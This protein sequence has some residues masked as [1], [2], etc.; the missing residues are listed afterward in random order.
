F[1]AKYR[2]V[3]GSGSRR[4]TSAHLCRWTCMVRRI[5]PTSEPARMPTVLIGEDEVLVRMT[6]ADYLRGCGYQVIEASNAD[7][8]VSVLKT[9][10]SVGVLFTDVQMPGSMDGFGLAQ[11][12]RR[13]RPGIRII[14]TS[15][16]MRAEDAKNLCENGPL[17]PKPYSF[18]E[19]E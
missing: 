16:V 15:G 3:A 12:V 11:W 19:L 4:G 1:C 14:V 6:I 5:P 8:G 13:E 2:R 10:T 17:V 9:E 7:E 18:E